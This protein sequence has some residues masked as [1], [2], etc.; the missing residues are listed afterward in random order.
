MT[1]I[2]AHEKF[3]NVKNFKNSKKIVDPPIGTKRKVVGKGRLSPSQK[4]ILSPTFRGFE[5]PIF[6]AAIAR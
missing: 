5:L 1:Q 3:K 4:A 6:S 2:P